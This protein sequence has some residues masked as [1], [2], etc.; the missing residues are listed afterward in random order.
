ML[1]EKRRLTGVTTSLP[2]LIGAVEAMLKATV[3]V[4]Q[5]FCS[6][7]GL[8]LPPR[9]NESVDSGVSRIF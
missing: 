6:Q 1:T 7:F 9:E 4:A 8:R 2:L 3:V 5:R